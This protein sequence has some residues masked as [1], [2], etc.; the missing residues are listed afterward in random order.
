MKTSVCINEQ[1]YVV[2]KQRANEEGRTQSWFIKKGLE[3]IL[4]VGNCE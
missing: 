2:L 4:G 3:Y 1:L